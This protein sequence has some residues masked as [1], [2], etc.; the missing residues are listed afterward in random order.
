M[1]GSEGKCA[2]FADR[3]KRPSNVFCFHP[4]FPTLSGVILDSEELHRVAYNDSFEH[5]DVRING[6]RVVWT[7]VSVEG[8]LFDRKK[9][10][11]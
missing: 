3:F 9:K 1:R 8:R 7:E 10:G 2:C 4:H 5:F 11:A 6:E